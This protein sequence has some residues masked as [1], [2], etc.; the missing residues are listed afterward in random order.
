MNDIW[1]IVHAERAALIDDLARLTPEQWAT[2]SL[3][4]GWDVHD[5]LAHLVDT[6][7]ATRVRFV[8]GLARARF[9]FHR[10]NAD[11]VAAQRRASPAD[12]LAA[13]RAVQ[14]WTATPPAPLETRLNEAFVHGEDIRRPLG[15]RGSYPTRYVLRT[16]ALQVRTDEKWGGGKQ[17]VAGVTL[18]ATDADH[19]IGEGPVV[20]GPA[21][22][23]LL[24]TC[25]RSVALT[26]LTGPGLERLAARL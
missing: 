4:E 5:V 13:F 7:R 10:Q 3:C 19:A 25:G 15:L 12:T 24:V 23:L 20:E 22:A 2:P 18:R 6:A 14:E 26:E 11:G 16:L 9:D 21:M 8:L 17:R 1:P